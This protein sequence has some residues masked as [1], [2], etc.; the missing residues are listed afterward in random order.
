MISY[1]FTSRAAADNAIDF[2]YAHIASALMTGI[3]DDALLLAHHYAA[4]YTINYY[5][6]RCALFL[7]D[8][9]ISI[10][11]LIFYNSRQ[12][13]SFCR[14]DFMASWQQR[15]DQLLISRRRA[16]AGSPSQHIQLRLW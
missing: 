6:L 3:F 15:P 4:V 9:Y 13:A 5:H 8:I 10:F 2:K 14:Y 11:S 7:A 1:I 16:S 12:A